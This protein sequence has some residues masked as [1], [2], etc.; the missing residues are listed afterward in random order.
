MPVATT[1][2]RAISPHRDQYDQSIGNQSSA[3]VTPTVASEA[4][5]RSSTAPQQLDLN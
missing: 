3:R 5:V 1:Q 4:Q 2:D